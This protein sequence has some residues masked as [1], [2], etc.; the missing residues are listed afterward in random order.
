MLLTLASY[1]D[2]AGDLMC[3]WLNEFASF[4]HMLVGWPWYLFHWFYIL[5][6]FNAYGEDAL[7]PKDNLEYNNLDKTTLKWYRELSIDSQLMLQAHL[8]DH[9]E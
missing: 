8:Y 5:A 2:N 9:T 3:R 4:F 1:G 6:I 7:P